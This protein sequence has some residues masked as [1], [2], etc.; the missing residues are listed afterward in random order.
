M[1]AADLVPTPSNAEA[2]ERGK[3]GDLFDEELRRLWY[4]SDARVFN[5]EAPLS[6][7]PLPIFKSGPLLRA[8]ER[9][10]VGIKQLNPTLVTLA[11]NHIMDHGIKGLDKTRE[12]LERNLIPHVGAGDNIQK[13]VKPFILDTGSERVGFYACAEHEYS[14]A[15]RGSPG[16]NPFDPLES[17]DHVSSLKA[18]CDYVV[19][20]Y[21]GGNEYF[22]FPAPYLQKRLRKLVEKGADF[23]VSQH[24]HCIGCFEYFKEGLIVYGQGNLLFDSNENNEFVSSGLLI[25]LDTKRPRKEQFI[26]IIKNGSGVKLAKGNASGMILEGFFGRS[27]EILEEGLVEEKFEELARS[28]INEYLHC[29]SRLGNIPTL[30]AG[31][32][33][34][35]FKGERYKRRH[36]LKLQ[37]TVRCEAHRELLLEGLRVLLEDYPE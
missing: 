19:V 30:I 27:E 18:D 20:L 29:F 10:I 26:P 21:H 24:S 11:N 22:R 4:S 32:A 33:M 15:S 8:S 13:A 16:V 31:I 23:I 25:E 5:L 6:D 35:F 14:L 37:N 36:L 12:L 7:E 28:K 2:F 34:A 1:I 3:T 9:S 17:P